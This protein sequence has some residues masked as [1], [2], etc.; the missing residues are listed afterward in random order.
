MKKFYQ[1]NEF[2]KLQYDWYEKLNKKGF[3]D[4][5]YYRDAKGRLIKSKLIRTT[6]K[7]PNRGQIRADQTS[8][9]YSTLQNFL[10]QAPFYPNLKE[11]YSYHKKNQAFNLISA[12]KP[13]KSPQPLKSQQHS[14]DFIAKYPT[15]KAFKA[16]QPII[17]TKTQYKLLEIY[18]TGATIREVS[19]Q[20]KRLKWQGKLCNTKKS[21][22]YSVYW[23]H[24]NL[25]ELKR[26]AKSFQFNE[27]GCKDCGVCKDCEALQLKPEL[28]KPIG[29][30]ND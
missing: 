11:I 14:A 19:K 10:V 4:I 8:Q 6:K 12:K 21:L 5:E 18:L 24:T 29:E 23:C 30:M 16:S 28:N 26:A 25:I 17:Y 15:F 27:D 9:H 13:L 2:R 22:K 7:S 1:S 20:M 3:E